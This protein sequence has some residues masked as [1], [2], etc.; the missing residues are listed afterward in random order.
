MHPKTLDEI[1]GAGSVR[2]YWGGRSRASKM[3]LDELHNRGL[4]RVARRE[5]G[6]RVYEA[7]DSVESKRSPEERFSRIL[8]AALQAMGPTTS[9]FLLKEL[10]H[11]SYLVESR[12]ARRECLR[13]LVASGRVRVDLVDSVEY[14]SLEGA[15]LGRRA[16]DKVHLLALFDPLVRDRDRFEHLWGW[17]YRFE[18]YTP[19][20]KRKL[21]DYALPVLWRENVIGWANA[22]VDDGVLTVEFG[23]VKQGPK[24]AR[25]KEA[26]EREVLLFGRLLRR[27]DA[28][29]RTFGPERVP[30]SAA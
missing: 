4:L 29:R 19:K 23:Y 7:V 28:W 24:D 15:N 13:S 12:G 22:K 6:I 17:T 11:F 21:G 9:Q 10:S 5:K 8:L 14:L 26:A 25:F 30:R 18:S 2:N 3:L 20:R 27:R 1:L 16:L